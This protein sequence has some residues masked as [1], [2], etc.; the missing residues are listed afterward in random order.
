M[1]PLTSLFDGV[2]QPQIDGAKHEKAK[3]DYAFSAILFDLGTKFRFRL[4]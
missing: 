4:I 3:R 2:E 1:K